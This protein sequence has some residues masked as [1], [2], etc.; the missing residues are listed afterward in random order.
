[1]ANAVFRAVEN[2]VP[3]VRCANTGVTCYVDSFGRIM[4]MLE[5]DDGRTNLRG[6]S[7][8]EM[9]LAAAGMPMTPYTRFG[10]WLF[11]RPC[12][13]ITLVLLMMAWLKSSRWRAK[14]RV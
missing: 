13:M 7:V 6:F 3:L 5:G 2:R 14:R 12:A 10:D 4:E 9:R 11:A 1:M 8:S